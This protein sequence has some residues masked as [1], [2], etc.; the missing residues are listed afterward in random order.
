MDIMDKIG[1][2][3]SN[4]CKITVTKTSKMAQRAKLKMYINQ[5]KNQIEED[6][7]AIG[8]KVYEKHVREENIDISKDLY[9]ECERID[10]LSKKIE[11]SIEHILILKNMKKCPQCYAEI[12]IDYNFCP[13]CGKKQNNENREKHIIEKLQND[14]INNTNKNEEEIV[15]EEKSEE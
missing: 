12:M 2:A 6:Y 13:N 9:E 5:C 8:K 14:K 3:T 11:N 4:T 10:E 15:I 7:R 1:Q